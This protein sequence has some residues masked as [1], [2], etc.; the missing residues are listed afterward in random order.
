[1]NADTSNEASDSSHQGEDEVTYADFRQEWLSE[2]DADG[3]SPLDLG[4]RFGAKLMTAWLGVTTDD[5]DFVVCD[6]SGDGG[7]DLAYLR[8][9]DTDLEVTTAAD[10]GDT[11]YVVQSKYGSSYQGSSTLLDEGEKVIRTLEGKNKSLSTDTAH[12]LEKVIRFR[13]KAAEADR[14]ILV[15][16]TTDPI[17][18]RERETLDEIKGRG[19][20]RLGPIFDVEEVSLRTIWDNLDDAEPQEALTVNLHGNLTEQYPGFIVGTVP[21]LALFE[22]LQSYQRQTGNLDQLYERNV[23]QFLGGRRKINRGIAKTLNETPERFGLYNNGITI[24]VSDYEEKS[25]LALQNPYVVNGCQT[26]RTIWQVLDG[27]LNVGGTA[28]PAPEEDDW[29]KRA[30]RGGVVT[31]IVRSDSAEINSITRYT[32]S[33]N[34]V[35]EQDF[36]ALDRGFQQWA[37]VVANDYDMYLEI[38]RGGIQS[39]KA[40]EKQHPDQRK[41]KD[42]VNAFDL[43]KVYGAGWLGQPGLAFG[44]NAPFLPGGSVY[45]EMTS[46]PGP[47]PFGAP[48]L[49]AAAQVKGMADEIGFGRSAASQSRR[50][51]RFLFYHIF[52]RM[53][54]HVIIMAPELGM[55]AAREADLTDALLKLHG[56]DDGMTLLKNAALQ[57]IDQ[58]LT[59]GN[60]NSAY[61]ETSFQSIHG[62]DLNG[63][64]KAVKFGQKEHSPLLLQAIEIHKG[65][66]SFQ[67]GAGPSPREQ[68]A[69][70]LAQGVGA[71]E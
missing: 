66:F 40:W 32:N 26:T 6:G 71:A 19:R 53:L 63:F 1:M 61:N 70:K 13:S 69:Q 29:R 57:L 48:D 27:R 33:Q 31:K 17:S 2:L 15:F 65:V 36:I 43:L 12:L 49:C 45:G 38:Q 3:L 58:Y 47:K 18:E 4:R 25:H 14:L 22:F 37:A 24:V 60:D 44:K 46:R 54:Q 5:E 64:L 21:L 11:W 7:I 55:P 42:Y 35:R 50:Q 56:D 20:Q 23:R 68:V 8:R 34:S 28:E 51:S 52:M 16:A 39:R 30:E 59:L 67:A 10:E 62:G 41:Y 9:A